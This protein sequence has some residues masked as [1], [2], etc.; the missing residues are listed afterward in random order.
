MDELKLTMY[1]PENENLKEYVQ[2]MEI[3]PKEVMNS[4]KS[5]I[6]RSKGEAADPV[7]VIG[8]LAPESSNPDIK[9]MMQASVDEL[10]NETRQKLV[11]LRRKK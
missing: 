7:G 4:I 2:P 10:L 11:D 8:R 5:I 6:E 1:N 3:E 9:R